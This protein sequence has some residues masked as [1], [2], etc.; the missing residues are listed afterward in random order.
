MSSLTIRK[1]NQGSIDR[2]LDLQGSC[3]EG[4]R[5]FKEYLVGK[6]ALKNGKILGAREMGQ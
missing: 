6:G 3:E 5:S 4:Y 1:K 2:G